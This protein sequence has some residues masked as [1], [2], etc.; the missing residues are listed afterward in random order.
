MEEIFYKQ[1]GLKNWTDALGYDAQRMQ[2]QV[3]AEKP[4]AKLILLAFSEGQELKTHTAPVDVFIVMLEGKAQF[5]LGDQRYLIQAGQ[6]IRI[7][8]QQPHALYA[9][10]NFKM[11]LVK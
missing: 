6:T 2:K 8:A 11:L 5:T 1:T 4:D 7:P 9:V 3:L 10:E